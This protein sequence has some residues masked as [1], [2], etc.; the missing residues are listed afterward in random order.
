MTKI[1]VYFDMIRDELKRRADE[2][3]RLREALR[4]IQ[5]KAEQQSTMPFDRHAE[6]FRMAR[7]ALGE[8]K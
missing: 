4:E 7:A 8:G 3:K 1:D 6:Y 5:E 2:I